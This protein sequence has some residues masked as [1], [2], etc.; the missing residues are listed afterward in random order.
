MF[1]D[2]WLDCIRFGVKGRDEA[3]LCPGHGGVYH[4]SGRINLN[5]AVSDGAFIS[6]P[7]PKIGSPAQST[8]HSP[9]LRANVNQRSMT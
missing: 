2:A 9:V 1:E 7:K 6:N 8:C 4:K 3:S 5:I